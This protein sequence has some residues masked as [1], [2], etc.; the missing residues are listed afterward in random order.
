[1]LARTFAAI[2][3]FVVTGNG[4]IAQESKPS[5]NVG[6]RICIRLTGDV[7][8]EYARRSGRQTPTANGTRLVIETSATVS[9][10][11]SDKH[12]RIEHS[13]PINLENKPQRLITLSAIVDP[14]K[15]IGSVAPREIDYS[16]PP[17]SKKNVVLPVATRP[18]VQTMTIELSDLKGL[19]CQTWELVNE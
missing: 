12:Y 3:V 7:A 2:A 19:N 10:R 17:T 1:M 18:E 9:E 14:A 6:D 13:C 15:I 4:L 8:K 11:L 16:S 5:I